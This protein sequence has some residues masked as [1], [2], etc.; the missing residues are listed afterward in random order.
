MLTVNRRGVRFGDRRVVT[1]G[2][3]GI[4][5]GRRGNTQRP[6][7]PELGEGVQQANP[8]A[9]RWRPLRRSGTRFGA[10]KLVDVHLHWYTCLMNC[11]RTPGIS[12]GWAVVLGLLLAVGP[13]VQSVAASPCSRAAA[14]QAATSEVVLAPAT[15]SAQWVCPEASPATIV[16]ALS[17]EPPPLDFGLDADDARRRETSFPHVE[18]IAGG[19][20]PPPLSP[21]LRTLRPVVLQI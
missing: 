20:S 1:A 14:P 9:E 4:R 17:S 15:P 12:G 19:P 16:R 3:A 8:Q 10:R 11:L 5:G 21:V 6:F 18:T 13:L 2:R 7:L